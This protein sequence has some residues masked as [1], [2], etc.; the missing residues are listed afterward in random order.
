MDIPNE[1][2]NKSSFENI[3]ID[4]VF[5][6]INNKFSCKK[7]VTLVINCLQDDND[8]NINIDYISKRILNTVY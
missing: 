4:N 7:I 2:P 3:Q 1:L 8:V 5:D 6:A